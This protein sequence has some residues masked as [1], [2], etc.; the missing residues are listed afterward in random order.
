[1]TPTA[2]RAIVLPIVLAALV[3]GVAAC[4][5]ATRS[6]GVATGTTFA[7]AVPAARTTPPAPT[8][9]VA[10]LPT[11]P[12]CGGGAY[13]PKTLLI[14]CGSGTTMATDV[15]WRSWQPATASGTGTIHLQ[16][17]GHPVTA[18]AALSLSQVVKGPVGP[19]FTLLTV[20]WTGTA[21]DGNPR[22]TYHLQVQG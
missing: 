18:P 21:P 4:G 3:G 13:E 15:A 11:V 5:S 16:V 20:T 14:V 1:V 9:T 12:N 22:D 10:L 8:T 19:Q 17:N 7:P 6:S 2:P